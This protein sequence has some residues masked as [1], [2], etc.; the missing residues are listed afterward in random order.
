MSYRFGLIFRSYFQGTSLNFI[1]YLIISTVQLG[2]TV[3]Y[4]ILFSQFY[5]DYR[6]ELPRKQA[7]LS[8]VT[9]ATPSLLTPAL[10]LMAAGLVLGKVSSIAIVSEL[11]VVLARGAFCSL[12]LVLFLLPALLTV[13]DLVVEKTT[14]GLKFV[15][16]TEVKTHE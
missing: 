8:T 10:I 14:W 9:S 7:V 13:L 15:R 3:D 5:I 16:K 4:A 12:M 1:G 6:K 2:A 11:G